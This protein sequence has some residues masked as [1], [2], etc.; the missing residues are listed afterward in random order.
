MAEFPNQE[1]VRNPKPELGTFTTLGA[2][3]RQTD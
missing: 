3:N 2:S 1:L